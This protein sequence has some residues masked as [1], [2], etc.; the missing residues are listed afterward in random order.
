MH[1]PK[2]T[3]PKPVDSRLTAFN[4]NYLAGDTYPD[5][6]VRERR[7][8]PGTLQLLRSRQSI[9]SIISNGSPIPRHL[10][11]Q[12]PAIIQ[13]NITDSRYYIQRISAV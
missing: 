12:Q 2:G 3:V 6:H 13:N 8:S 9:D 7:S 10:R 4:I 11:Q 5:Q 1:L